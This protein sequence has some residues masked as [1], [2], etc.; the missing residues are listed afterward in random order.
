MN[1]NRTP[2]AMA[3]AF[4][5]V[6]VKDYLRVTHSFEDGVITGLART[7]AAEIE[8]YCDLA[9]LSQ[10]ITATTDQWPGCIIALPVGPVQ[11]GA[12]VSV[13]V[14]EADGT[15]TPVP[16]GWWLEAGRYPRLHF[17]TTP[18]APLR[19]TYVAGYGDDHTTLP[20]DL[21]HAIAAQAVRSYSMRGDDPSPHGP[22]VGRGGSGITLAPQTIRIC[23]RY[24]KVRV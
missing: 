1:Y 18:G 3:D 22:G 8:G 21:L 4:S 2:I 13:D 12:T 24:R 16:S 20:I 9:L 11:D 7:A 5:L 15:T 17:T 23:S 19:V 10:T 6:A 14:I